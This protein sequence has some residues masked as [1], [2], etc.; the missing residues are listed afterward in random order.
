MKNI[1]TVIIDHSLQKEHFT[2]NVIICIILIFSYC[3]QKRDYLYLNVKSPQEF[4]CQRLKNY[5]KTKKNNKKSLIKIINL[6]LKYHNILNLETNNVNNH[7]ISPL[8]K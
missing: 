6:K 8:K 1:L 2:F 5:R 7:F 3:P 4:W